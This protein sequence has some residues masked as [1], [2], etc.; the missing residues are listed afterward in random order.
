MSGGRTTKDPGTLKLKL[1][2]AALKLDPKPHKA[3][4][5]S[6]LDELH[7]EVGATVSSAFSSGPGSC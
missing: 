1:H 6:A 5:P 4:I 7:L 2:A 3:R